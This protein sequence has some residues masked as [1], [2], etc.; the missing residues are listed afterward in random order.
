M[1]IQN[2]KIKAFVLFAYTKHSELN[3]TSNAF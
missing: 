2:I 1:F 3:V